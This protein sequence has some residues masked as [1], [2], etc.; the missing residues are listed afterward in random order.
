MISISVHE[1]YRVVVAVCDADLLGKKFVEGKRV[2]NL[3]NFY[4]GDEVSEAEAEKIM[5]EQA[6]EDSTFN[7]AGEKSIQI[8]V[9]LGIVSEEGVGKVDGVPFALGLM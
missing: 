6:G 8:A 1:A 5:K 2:L 9:K 3:T 4:N 7:I